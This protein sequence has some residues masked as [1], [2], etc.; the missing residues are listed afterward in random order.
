MATLNNIKV[1]LKNR[2]GFL[3][4]I[5]ESFEALDAD[6][7]NT[8]SGLVF[9]DAHALVSIEIIKDVHPVI[10]LTDLQLNTHLK[11]LRESNVLEVL[12]DVY[13]GQSDIDEETINENISAFDKAIY[14]R[15]VLKVGEQILSTK[16]INE[17]SILSKENLTQLR[18][19]LNGSNDGDNMNPN[20]PYHLGYTSRYRREID[21]IKSRFNNND[22]DMLNT[23]TL[24]G[25]NGLLENE[26]RWNR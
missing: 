7:M 13:Q 20:F 23:Q 19:D 11:N 24:G 22:S 14:L 10:D 9:Q 3:K 8:D 25:C 1:L 21:F 4:P 16:K 15:M 26:Y 18:L 17:N 2:V 5:D 12:N 6:N